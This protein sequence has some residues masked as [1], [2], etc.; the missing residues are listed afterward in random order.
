MYK[1][2]DVYRYDR[3]NDSWT[4]LQDIPFSGRG[5]AYGVAVGNKAYMGFGLTSN[6][7][8]PTDWWE[9][10]MNNNTWIQKSSF[11]AN[12]RLHPAMVVVN[13][14]I[15]MGCGNNNNGNLGDWWEYDIS[16]DLWTQKS[17]I[18]GNNRHHPYYFGIGNYA[19]VGF[20]HGSSPGPGSNPNSKVY[21]FDH[22][23]FPLK[24]PFGLNMRTT[25]NIAKEIANL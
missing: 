16:L 13:N 7:L 20:G 18:I 3:S 2:Q 22:M 25:I 19:Y 14:K 6:G 10:D 5:Y 12:G 1:R 17:N 23:T 11:P 8:L 15:Y 21:I 4:Q 24:I 9:Y